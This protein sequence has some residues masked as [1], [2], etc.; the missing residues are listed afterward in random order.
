M[1][2]KNILKYAWLASIVLL[3]WNAWI[4]FS[5][6]ET[7]SALKE[8]LKYMEPMEIFNKVPSLGY[9]ISFAITTAILSI[10]FSLEEGR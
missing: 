8:S 10:L 6:L 3:L 5:T 2:K 1:S 4:V 7:N 9:T